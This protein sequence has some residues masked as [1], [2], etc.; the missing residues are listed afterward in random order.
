[1]WMPKEQLN[2]APCFEGK[3]LGQQGNGHFLAQ[4][5]DALAAITQ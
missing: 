4:V 1:M 2:N 5:C 3:H